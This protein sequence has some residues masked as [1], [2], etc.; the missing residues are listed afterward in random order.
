MKLIKVEGC[1]GCGR[2]LMIQPI[3]NLEIRLETQPLDAQTAVQAL[4][5][6]RNLWTVT[7]N[8]ASGAGAAE[9]AALGSSGPGVRRPFV[10]AEHVCPTKGQEALSRRRSPSVS[11]SVQV[12][13]QSPPAGR[14]AP[15]SGPSAGPDSVRSAATRDSETQVA[16]SV[17]G[18]LIR[19]ADTGTYALIELGSTLIDAFHTGDCP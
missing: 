14:T 11:P 16:C 15:F 7:N 13:P 5:A 2:L 18:N 3:A 12:T 8:H 9:L 19:L 4:V 10:V 6:G 17:C 1:R